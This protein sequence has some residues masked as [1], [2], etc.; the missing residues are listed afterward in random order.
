MIFKKFIKANRIAIRNKNKRR[1]EK[2]LANKITPKLIEVFKKV[3]AEIEEFKASGTQ[4][5]LNNRDYDKHVDATYKKV[6][7][8]LKL[9]FK[10]ELE[11]LD[12]PIKISS[13]E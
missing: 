7:N 13:N 3:L 1:R 10:E 8:K 11:N 9:V 2:E 4:I 6:K 5:F 12:Y